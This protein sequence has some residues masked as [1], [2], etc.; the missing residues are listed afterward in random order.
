MKKKRSINHIKT[1]KSQK[2]NK[3]HIKKR[4]ATQ[5]VPQK[6]RPLIQTNAGKIDGKN[7]HLRGNSQAAGLSR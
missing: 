1:R 6:N 3:K 4:N 5:K 2:S 7:G